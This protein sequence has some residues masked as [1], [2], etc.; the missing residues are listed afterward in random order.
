MVADFIKKQNRNS[1]KKFLLAIRGVVVLLI[2]LLLVIANIRIYKKREKLL[3]QIETLKNKIQDTR[4]KNYNLKEGILK[5]N[6]AQYT[7]KIAREELDM[8]KPGEKVFSFVMAK[9]QQAENNNNQKNIFQAW[10]DWIG[11]WIK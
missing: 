7:E 3:S 10:F 11:Q 8:Q 6:D 4:E 9:D 5:S 1:Q 2:V